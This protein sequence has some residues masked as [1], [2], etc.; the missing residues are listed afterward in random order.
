MQAAQR[1]PS[2][3]YRVNRTE[4]DKVGGI[5]MLYNIY[6]VF[7]RKCACYVKKNKYLCGLN[8]VKT[9]LNNINVGE[10]PTHY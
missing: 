1:Q 4:G 8:K 3:C 10:N 9:L 5:D 6:C 2:L 7:F